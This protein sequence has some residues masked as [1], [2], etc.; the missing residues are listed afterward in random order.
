MTYKI[1]DTISG[2]KPFPKFTNPKSQEFIDSELDALEFLSRSI[3]RDAYGK[4]VENPFIADLATYK[5]RVAKHRA[6]GE[7]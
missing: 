3:C 7:K 2:F 6:E 4:I 1:P 5:E